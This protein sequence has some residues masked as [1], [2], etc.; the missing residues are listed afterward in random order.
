MSLAIS[1]SPIHNTPRPIAPDALPRIAIGV[2]SYNRVAELLVSLDILRAI[3][4]PR[5]KVSLVVID[6]ASSDGTREKV[7]QMYGG[8]VEVMTLPENIGAIARNRVMLTRSEPYIFVFDEDSTP[9]LP[10]T[11]RRIVEFMEAN[12]YFGVLCLRSINT[13]TGKTEYGRWGDH[14]RRRLRSGGYEGLYVAGNGMCFR[15]EAI[16]QTEGYDESM[17]WGG[18]EHA[19]GLELLYHDIP[20]AFVP[21]FALFHRHAPR[22]IVPARALEIDTRNNIWIA[23]KSFPPALAVP[24]ATIHTVRRLLMSIIR[25]RDGGV[26]AVM[27]GVRAGIAGLPSIW[28]RRKP[29][30]ISRL[31]QNNRWFF[32]MFYASRAAREAAAVKPVAGNGNSAGDTNA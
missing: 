31:A 26:A 28:S 17:F 14:S 21:E 13:H 6:N 23:F 11:I 15:S 19:L 1:R 20:I 2:L 32:S 7:L 22:A 4:Y 29:V 18:E 24:V 30:P 5:E 16:Q 10:E 12:P 3:D 25:R 8:E 27:R 9:E